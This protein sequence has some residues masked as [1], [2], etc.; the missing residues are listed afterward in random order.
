[1]KS[2]GEGETTLQNKYEY[3]ETEKVS[4][5]EK[6]DKVTSCETQGGVG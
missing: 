4:Q 5:R 6:K 1:M 3:Q 2:G